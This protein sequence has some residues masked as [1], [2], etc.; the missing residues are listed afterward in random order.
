[1]PKA[2][3][4][5][6][7]KSKLLHPALTS[8]FE[9]T[10]PIPKG[11]NDNPGYLD[12]NGLQQFTGI[13]QDT[14]NLLCCDTVL[15]GSNIGTMDITGDYHGVTVRHANRRIYDD[16]IDMTFY[17]DAENYLPIRY[18][19]TWI[20]YIVGESMAETGNRPGSTK[21]NYF[22]RLNYPDLYIA[23]QGLSVTKFE[24]TGSKSSY[25][26]K[27]L[28]YQF[29]NAFPISITSMPVS[30]ETSSLLKCTVSFSYIRY[31][32]EPTS[33]NDPPPADGS[34]GGNPPAVGDP[35]SPINQAAFNNPQFT[36]GTSDL[37]LPGLEGT[38]AL[39]AGGVPLSAANAS[40]NTV[41]GVTQSDINSA[42]AAERALL[43]R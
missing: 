32:V 30:Y 4:I 3:T 21:P 40:G 20:K 9:V 43:N 39:N 36:T 24:R 28:T 17:V 19:E 35:S 27:T 23:K 11:L 42:L 33:S 15:P 8:H 31:Y 34:S 18:F 38:G 26:G 37:N 2:R 5:A 12:A 14:L 7:I 6:D 13:K 16:R 41:K 25:T 1:M 10:I 22:Y 29:V